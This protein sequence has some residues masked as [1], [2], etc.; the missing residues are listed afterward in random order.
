M[1]NKIIS[2]KNGNTFTSI[3]EDGTMERSFEDPNNIVIDHPSSMD[4]KITNYCTPEPGD[5]I[6]AYCHE[7]SNLKGKHCDIEKLI[8]VIDELPPGIEMAIGGGA[9]QMHPDFSMFVKHLK[10]KQFIPNLTINQKHLEKDFF[11]LKPLIE[12]K[13]IYGI[14]I[15]YS[16]PRYHKEIEKYLKISD[17][18]VFH[19]IMGINTVDEVDTLIELCNKNNKQCKILLLGYKYFGYGINYFI[20]NK[21]IEDNKYQWFIKIRD[22]MGKENLTTSFDNL[23]IEQLKLKR[24]FKQESWDKFFLGDD[25]TFSMYIDAVEQ[26]YGPTSTSPK[27]ERVKFSQMSLLEFFKTKRKV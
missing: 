2:Y 7:E 11:N 8:H 15:S 18:I 14:G 6:C 26:E 23:A 12:E 21:K 9:A 27:S 5:P 13:A 17:N 24:F 3:Y 19:M 25:F 16:S 20:K 22:V 4:V 10:S 1:T